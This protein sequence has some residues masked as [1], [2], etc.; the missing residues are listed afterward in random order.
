MAPRKSSIYIKEI[1][2]L[3]QNNILPSQWFKAPLEI[4]KVFLS[5]AGLIVPP[6]FLYLNHYLCN[7]VVVVVV[8]FFPYLFPF[9]VLLMF[10]Q[11]EAHVSKVDARSSPLRFL[12]LSLCLVIVG[13][14][15][16]WLLAWLSLSC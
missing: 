5:F 12:L 8:Y 9:S 3:L 6:T 11:H 13:F 14:A 15:A 16:T 4:I 7:C 10:P 1:L 2:W